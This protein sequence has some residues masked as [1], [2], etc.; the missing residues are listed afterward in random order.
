MKTVVLSHY[1]VLFVTESIQNELYT[2]IQT[3]LYIRNNYL[4]FQYSF[5]NSCLCITL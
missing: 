1:W 3:T 5:A 4:V 2:Y